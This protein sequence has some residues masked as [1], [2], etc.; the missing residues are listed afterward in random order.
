MMIITSHEQLRE[1]VIE[2]IKKD[3]NDQ[4]LTAIHELLKE[5]S[6]TSLINYLP[7]EIGKQFK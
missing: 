2:Q 3:I 6:L 1:V 7:E 4:D 5:C